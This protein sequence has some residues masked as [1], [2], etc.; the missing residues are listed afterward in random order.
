MAVS[1]LGFG[2]YI[3][4]DLALVLDVLPDRDNAAKNLGVFNMAS[5]IP[6]S[7]APALAPAILAVGGGSYG[8]LYIAAGVSAVIGALAIVRVK[9][10]R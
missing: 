8:A 4:V 5:A 6:F 3:A 10:V 1:G 7:L 9:G 2:L